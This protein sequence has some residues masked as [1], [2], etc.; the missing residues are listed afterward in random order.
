MLIEED[1]LVAKKLPDITKQ[2][3]SV[4][5]DKLARVGMGEI[6][7][8]VNLD[9][10]GER[11]WVPAKINATV[12]IDDEKAKGI[13][14]S[15]LY[16]NLK[17]ELANQSMSLSLV[18]DLLEKFVSSQEGLSR[19]ATLELRFNYLILRK[20]LK[21]SKQGWREYPI[22]LKGV[23]ENGGLSLSCQLDIAYSSTCP[24][25][26]ALSRQLLK[27]KFIADWQGQDLSLDAVS[28]WMTKESSIVATPHA[29]RSYAYLT[30]KLNE[31]VDIAQFV[32]AMIDTA[33]NTLGTPVQAAVKRQDE[34]EFA[35]LNASNLMFCE[36]AARKLKKLLNA[37][38]NIK[39]FKLMVEHRESL[40]PHNAIA[41]AIKGVEGGFTADFC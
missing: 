12:S 18:K 19:S 31:D 38:K 7:M 26:A 17:N 14:M 27:E 16:L 6:E 13:H 15:R 37:D 3:E 22:V 32:N 34:Q 41:M 9:W 5:F 21:S 36:D 30:M 25:S 35:R 2:S 8:P 10:S 39:D 20:A 40:H 29:Q 4:I 28:E 33:E 23:L 24:C 1:K 11:Q